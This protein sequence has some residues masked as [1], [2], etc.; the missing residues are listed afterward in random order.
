MRPIVFLGV[1]TVA[2]ACVPPGNS[3]PSDS[4]PSVTATPAP[5]VRP[6]GNVMTA[7][8]EDNFDR[9]GTMPALLDASPALAM[10]KDAAILKTSGEAGKAD[11]AEVVKTDL[12]LVSKPASDLGPNWNQVNTTLWHIENGKMCVAG[13]K[14]HGVWLNKVLPVNARIEFDASTDS[15]DGDFK[16]EVWGDGQSAAT[17]VSY[18]N[19]TSYLAIVGGWKNTFHVLARINEHGAD[20]QEIKIDKTSDDMKEK[21]VASGQTY[22]IKVERADGKTVRMYVDGVEYL[23]YTDPT[24][25]VGAGHDHFGFNAYWDHKVCY[26][27]VRVTPISPM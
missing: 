19:A 25:L 10:I 9:P 1:V 12:P 27:N 4:G 5:V 23:A 11:G 13:A 24:P 26:D 15:A 21:P 17:S 3:T 7:P 18:T 16:A 2:A 8:F 20:R 22:H 6:S 14:N